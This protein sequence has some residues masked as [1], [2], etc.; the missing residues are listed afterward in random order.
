MKNILK[1]AEVNPHE[2]HI[3]PHN[4]NYTIPRTWG[5]YHLL[6]DGGKINTKVFRFGNHPIRLKELEREFGTCKT[7]ALYSERS[8][9]KERADLENDNP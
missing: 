5:V 8:L 2:V 6:G 3:D 1:D 9:A 4:P 7:V